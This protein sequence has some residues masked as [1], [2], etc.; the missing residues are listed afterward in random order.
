MLIQPP[1]S[2]VELAITRELPDV[3][4]ATVRALFT[5]P[6]DA[7]EDG[8]VAYQLWGDSTMGDAVPFEAVITRLPSRG[9]LFYLGRERG[10]RVATISDVGFRIAQTYSFV[11]C[12]PDEQQSPPALPYVPGPALIAESRV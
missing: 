8:S 3:S 10:A 11:E 1:R 2:P 12:A 6:A 5:S 7:I 9:Q 4:D